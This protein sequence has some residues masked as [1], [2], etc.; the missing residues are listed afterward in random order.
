MPSIKELEAFFAVVE[1]GS[2]EAA[3]RRLNA[4]APAISKRISEL[5]TDLG[6]RLFERSTRRCQITLRGRAL[7]P[8][9]DRILADIAEIRR[10]VGEQASLAGHVRLGVS[11]TIAFALLSE[12][13]RK[14]SNELPRLTIDV[15]VGASV[16][17]IRRVVTREMDIACVVGPALE[18][19]LI[20]EPF[21]EVPLSWIARGPKWTEEPLT[22]EGLSQRTIL[23]PA[24]GRHIAMIEGWFKSRGLRPERVITC[25]SLAT[26]LKMTA[27]GMGLS[28]VP[29]ESAR[30]EIDAG[31]VTS[32]PVK[33]RLPSN[34]LVMTYPL[35][36]LE[37]ALDAFICILREVAATLVVRA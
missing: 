14:A 27:L 34:S 6:V 4:T 13:L 12:I 17:L 24:G 32:V 21:W 10:T 33:V 19:T 7:L 25:N 16:D 5:E 3:A 23:L 22:I 8:F 29:V 36:Q 35:G 31:A 2:F 18:E 15:E 26:T 11:E 37:P 30:Q 1:G 9:A 28:L 20:S